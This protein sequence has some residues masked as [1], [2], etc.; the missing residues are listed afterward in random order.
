MNNDFKTIMWLYSRDKNEIISLIRAKELDYIYYSRDS[1]DKGTYRP[2]IAL[3]RLTLNIFNPPEEVPKNI[4][5]ILTEFSWIISVCLNSCYSGEFY[6]GIFNQQ[7]H[8]WDIARRYSQ[9]AMDITGEPKDSIFS[10]YEMLEEY[11][12]LFKKRDA[13]DPLPHELWVDPNC[14]HAT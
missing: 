9:M 7:D 5:E 12:Y 13:S 2:E 11:G 4:N 6:C 10:F 3:L 8:F 1:E 14:M